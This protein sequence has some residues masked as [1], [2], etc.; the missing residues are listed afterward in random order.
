MNLSPVKAFITAR[1]G[2]RFEGGAGAH[3]SEALE[4]RMAGAGT[5]SAAAYLE[6][7]RADE[8]ELHELAGLLTISETYFYREPRHLRLL[9]E[10]LAPELLA[11]R[12]GGG[13]ARILSVGCST[14]EEPYSI[15]M[16][17]R[18][19]YGEAAERLFEV[20]AGDIDRRALEKARAGLYGAFAFRALPS[21]LRERYFTAAADQRHEIA[22]VVRR[23]VRLRY[24]NAR[25][26]TYPE[27]LAGQDVVFFRNVSIYFDTAARREMQR[28]LQ[29]LLKPGGYLIVGASETLANDFALMDLGERDGVFLFTNRP[30][31]RRAPSPPTGS[32]HA[33]GA[34]FPAVSPA[35][36]ANLIPRPAS[37]RV[38]TPPAPASDPETAETE[39]REALELAC[40]KRFEEALRRLAPHCAAGGPSAPHLTLRAHILF[41][42]GDAAEAVSAVARALELDP[43][44]VDALLLQGRI[45]RFRGEM[46]RATGYFRQ[47][48]YHNPDCWPAHYHLAELY[49]EGGETE[50]ARREYRIV[51][52]Q[53]RDDTATRVT[54]PWLL[55][56][57]IKDLRFL[58]ETRLSRLDAAAG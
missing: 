54:G 58:C 12:A 3:L 42:R 37:S 22:D 1:L 27:D 38:S 43:W 31:G 9:A 55:A 28:R 52:R 18:E 23:Q 11:R 33:N 50:L 35:A 39:Y 2:L 48:V 8:A 7:L 25:A 51:L 24:F 44:S 40:E 16:A 49:R 10:T 36:L 29:A 57:A 13:K 34:R 26:E 19:R 56:V 17:L 46:E 15:V 14:G 30:A 20:T 21:E 4:R 41:E 47:A 32:R 45:A 5:V 6:R 53:L